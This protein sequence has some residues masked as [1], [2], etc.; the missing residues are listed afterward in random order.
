[1]LNLKS[2]CKCNV[3]VEKVGATLVFAMICALFLFGCCQND[4]ADTKSS[5]DNESFKNIP[6]KYHSIL[7]EFQSKSPERIISIAPSTTELLYEYGVGEYL[8]GATIPHDYPPEAADLP[9]IGDMSLDYERIIALQPDLLIGEGNLFAGMIENIKDLGI[10]VLLFD[11]RSFQELADDLRILDILF[12]RDITNELVDE[13][14]RIL[15]TI[16]EPENK[17]KVAAIISSTP[18]ILAAGD[19]YLVNLIGIAGGESITSD[20]P[21]DYITLS[22][23][24]MILLNPDVIIYTFDGIRNDLLQDKA[25]SGIEAIKNDR[26]IKVDPDIVLRPTLRSLRVGAMTLRNLFKK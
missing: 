19:S 9:S 2:K 4:S 6:Q 12:K 7:A 22:K 25:L 8:V 3:A 16:P 15:S 26:I 10:P 24:D 23:E 13:T 1:M 21:G 14:K 11:T 5:Q 17:P 18:L 20:T